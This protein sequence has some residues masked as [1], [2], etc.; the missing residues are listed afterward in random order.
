MLDQGRLEEAEQ[1]LSRIVGTCT[2]RPTTCAPGLIAAYRRQLEA[3][4]TEAA[5][6]KIDELSPAER[7]WY[8]FLEGMIAE[9]TGDLG[10]RGRLM[11]KR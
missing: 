4:R 11:M 3:A 8:R 6:V 1:A 5:Q 7:G 2:T 9:L 10:R